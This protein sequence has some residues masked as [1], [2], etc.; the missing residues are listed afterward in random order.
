MVVLRSVSRVLLASRA[1]R[2]LAVLT[3]AALVIGGGA[4][5]A[6]GIAAPATA[7]PT[8][9]DAVKPVASYTFDGDTGTKVVDSSGNGND[10]TWVG[11]PSY[12]SGIAG[13][14]ASVS[15]GAN[16][17]K[18]PLVA[19][20]TDASSSFSYEFWM[21]E[22]SR[23]SY[24]PIVSN[25]NFTHCYNKGLTLYNQTTPGVLEACWGQTS[26]GST[27]EYV[28][29][30][31]GSVVGEWH[32]VAV[33]VDRSAN[34]AVFYVDGVQQATSPA[35]SITSTTAF[36][37]GLAFN[38]GGLSGSET[39]AADGATDASIDDFNFYDAAISADQVA[40]DFAAS[41]PASTGYTIAFDG[42]GATGGSTASQTMTLGEA[43]A[44]TKNGFTRT[45]Y[46]FVGWAKSASGAVAY[47]D[48]Q[49]VSDLSTTAGSTVTLHAVWNRLR[50]AGDSVA[51]I[52][53]YDFDNDSGSIVRDSSGNG[54]DGT[55][56][57]TASFEAG[58]EGRS[59]YVNSPAGSQQGV[60]FF[61]LPLIAGKTDG[62]SSFS[63]VFWLKEASS[64]SDS[65]IVSNQDFVHCYN[66][67]ATLYNT[68]GQPGILRACFGQNG[69]S[70][71][72][73][74]LPQV[75][76]TSVIDSWHQVAV[77]VDRSAGTMTTYLDG[78]VTAQSTGLTSAFN[79]VSGYA[80][81][82]GADGSG[83]DAG[84]GFVNADIDDFDFYAAPI[85]AGQIQNDYAATNPNTT[86]SD[87]GSTID[88]GFVS[89]TFRAPQV[90][91]GGDFSQSVAGL[92]NGGKVTSYTKVSGDGWL[93]VSSDG[94]VSGTAP[95]D[96]PD[97]PSSITV[98]ATDGTT[99]SQIEV[100][101]T[102]IGKHASAQL[103]T[104]TWNL[105]DAGTHVNDSTFKD[106]A[107]IAANGLQVIGLQEDDGT[108]A[109]RLADALGWHAVE[110]EGGTAI[111]SAYPVG[112]AADAKAV[113]ADPTASATVHALGQDLKVWSVGLD[114][115][116]YGPETACVDGT[117]DA[118]A[119]IA[120]EKASERYS[121]AQT[122]A[123]AIAKDVPSAETT[124]VIMLGDL[125]SPSAAD[126]TAATADA[127]CGVG[128]TAWPVPEQL[129]SAGLT[130]SFRVANPD[131]AKA[132]GNTWSPLV[133]TNAKSG[134]AEPQ[135]RIDY[136]DFAGSP[137][138][139]LG[140][141]TLVAG[142]PS[143]KNVLSNSWT[144]DHRAVVTTFAIGGVA[145]PAPTATVAKST[146]TYQKGTEPEASAL[147][148]A[149]GASSAPDGAI[150]AI[151]AS[152]VDFGTVGTYHASVTAK[153]PDSGE[154]SQPVDVTVRVVP[155][156]T[157][158]LERS[159][160]T[161]T[162]EQGAKLSET[163][164]QAA[165]NPTLNVDGKI[166]IDL[167]HVRGAVAGSYPV[168][169]TGTDA[170]GFTA[171][172]QAQVVIAEGGTTPGGGSTSVPGGGSSTH[173]S[174]A[175][176]GSSHGSGDGLAVTG[177]DDALVVELAALFLLAGAVSIGVGALMGRRRQR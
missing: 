145:A 96:V 31:Q 157:V 134:G 86:A 156:I 16:Y 149:V 130:D 92:W 71:S 40:A 160:A 165:L 136:V 122:V 75:S 101:T 72:Q 155:V 32:Q 166:A 169:V 168:T 48:G 55:W 59:A 56:S 88:K 47:T 94:V 9:E 64:S 111:L 117:K 24:G 67:G 95:S 33:V 138:T 19:G 18:L 148:K 141:N 52:I 167:S 172:A 78:A 135:D 14:A 115:A 113:S 57:G 100:E 10:A 74:Y 108:V 164:V 89:D 144:S 8:P 128:A 151:D 161:F 137:L 22:H 98:Q 81:A 107:V 25:Q 44:L 3:A 79:L 53:S 152:A 97:N 171:Q 147:L 119:L 163:Q 87:S 63:Y 69:S 73:N 110:G 99:T 60:N 41:N 61:R 146:V 106:L 42:N 70:T 84:D 150:L 82:V 121:Q 177:S 27:N 13:K 2:I 90:R 112:A 129:T 15:G 176:G 43:T 159:T 102:V 153:D 93:H 37:S 45:G 118:A 66:K 158:S 11:T 68:A 139:V 133:T 39:D 54:N 20:K 38:I 5:G 30:I 104:A 126:W 46:Q 124:P 91:A 103:A 1:R 114:D 23:T 83:A 36:N 173:H 154:V 58:V 109:T 175:P 6:L 132:P 28:H 170:Y 7:A 4:I 120:A 26:G 34:T 21:Q 127:H 85:S 76:S 105:W 162:L 125:E 116:G 35:G 17:V 140:S 49:S 80:F 123:A 174:P 65:P 142:W 62:A 29:N 143:A 12:A 131:P 77:V 51:P 50:A